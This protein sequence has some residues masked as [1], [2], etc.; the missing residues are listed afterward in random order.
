MKQFLFKVL[1]M[2]HE[3]RIAYRSRYD[4]HRLGS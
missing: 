4:A 1:L 3:V 2:W